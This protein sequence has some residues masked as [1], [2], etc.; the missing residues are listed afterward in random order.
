MKNKSV[1]LVFWV[2]LVICTIFVAFGAI[3]PKQLEKLTQN[4]TTFIALHFS[5]YYL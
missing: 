3:F 4:I 1:S 2:S 5:W